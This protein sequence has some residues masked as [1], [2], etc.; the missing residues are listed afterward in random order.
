MKL[1]EMELRIISQ[2][3]NG[4][5]V[6]SEISSHK[7]PEEAAQGTILVSC[8]DGDRVDD[9]FVHHKKC[10]K[11]GRHHLLAAAGGP[12][13]GRWGVGDFLAE[14]IDIARRVKTIEAIVLVA[15]APC[16]M[17]RAQGMS[18]PDVLNTLF[19]RKQWVKQRFPV[20]A[21]RKGGVAC[22][23]H[24]DDGSKMRT[25]HACKDAWIAC[26]DQFQ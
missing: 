17:A 16:A 9:I 13:A 14:E 23:L 26:C 8:A 1:T 2:L 12:I 11:H 18:I 24:V 5:G 10:H 4:L 19:A 25:Y 7:I 22:H 3:R 15:H 21:D 20:Y 6:L